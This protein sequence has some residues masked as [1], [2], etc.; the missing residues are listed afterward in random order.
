MRFV[1]V[2][3]EEQQATL[4]LHRTRELL[5]GSDHVRQRPAWTSN[6]V[7]PRSRQGIGRAGE[8]ITWRERRGAAGNRQIGR[9]E[10]RGATA[11][12][13]ALIAASKADR[14]VHAQSR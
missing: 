2:K 12:I 11:A 8:L 5:S 1:P 10:F 14:R 9:E 3:S 4:T 6:G 13:Q 7:R